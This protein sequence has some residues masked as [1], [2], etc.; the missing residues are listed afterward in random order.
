MYVAELYNHSL[1]H[2]CHRS[3]GFLRFSPS[4]F[5]YMS[6]TFFHDLPT[7]MAKLFGVYRISYRHPQ[8]N[9]VL[10]VDVLVMENLFY[11]RKISRIFDLKGSM[12]NRRANATG[13]QSE[14]LL[15]ENLMESMGRLH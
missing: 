9:R 12:R 15:D 13:Q 2:A 7:V 6:Q 10:K 5:E 4:Y 11:E 8:T 14:V 1:A 3:P